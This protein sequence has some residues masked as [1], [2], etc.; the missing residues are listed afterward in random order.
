L[1]RLAGLEMIDVLRILAELV[2]VTQIATCRG[3]VKI[4]TAALV[5]WN[6]HVCTIVA[7]M[8]GDPVGHEFILG[9]SRCRR[10]NHRRARNG[11][12]SKK[13]RNLNQ[14]RVQVRFRH[15]ASRRD[16]RSAY[17]LLTVRGVKLSRH[18]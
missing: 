8:D 7:R 12:R 10:E 9:G 2:S 4:S 13:A 3:R 5:Q 15:R 1:H 14:D 11:L 6:Q 18:G 16:N 17:N